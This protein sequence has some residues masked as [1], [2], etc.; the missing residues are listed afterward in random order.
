MG[1][2]AGAFDR[3]C[4]SGYSAGA[5]REGFA[6]PLTHRGQAREFGAGHHVFREPFLAGEAELQIHVD[7]ALQKL[8]RAGVVAADQLVHAEVVKGSTVAPGDRVGVAL[9]DAG[10]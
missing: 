2:D 5:I 3:W 9:S 6:A 4:E 1:G 10:E 8:A 7:R